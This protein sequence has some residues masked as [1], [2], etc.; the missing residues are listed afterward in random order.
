MLRV[1]T[2][3]VASILKDTRTK[4]GENPEEDGILEDVFEVTGMETHM[5]LT[6]LFPQCMHL[7]ILAIAWCG[8]LI[9]LLHQN[10]A[11]KEASN[12]HSITFFFLKH[13]LSFPSLP[14][15][16]DE[17]LITSMKQVIMYMNI[18]FFY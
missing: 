16:I 10:R 4:R 2:G 12:Y 6:H 9:T 7:E 14:A 15:L 3:D 1:T 5:R 8:A 13:I 17:L 11:Q 18:V